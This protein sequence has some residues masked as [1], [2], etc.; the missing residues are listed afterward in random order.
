MV[1]NIA[2]R[3][4]YWE[5]YIAVAAKF[6]KRSLRECHDLANL[7]ILNNLSALKAYITE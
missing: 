7:I 3:R 4:I 6:S 5:I 1:K 2:K